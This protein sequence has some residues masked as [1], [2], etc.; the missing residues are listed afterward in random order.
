M[1]IIER[2]TGRAQSTSP[3]P[4]LSPRER[5]AAELEYETSLL[6]SLELRVRFGKSLP[7]EL[8]AKH[9]QIADLQKQ[10]DALTIAEAEDAKLTQLQATELPAAEAAFV[11][12]IDDFKK[13]VMALRR[14]AK[15]LL[16]K[17]EA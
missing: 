7:E 11:A 12:D 1:S 8:E 14:K 16:H 5:V 9:T 3:V 15:S 2:I 6:P 10:L 4:V 17:R 13:D